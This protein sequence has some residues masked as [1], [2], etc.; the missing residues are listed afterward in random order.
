[1]QNAGNVSR[2]QRVQR[3]SKQRVHA[4]ETRPIKEKA[5][6]PPEREKWNLETWRIRR[7]SNY[8]SVWLTTTSSF[9]NGRNY[10]QNAWKYNYSRGGG[11]WAGWV[12][13]FPGKSSSAGK[14]RGE[15]G[16]RE[17]CAKSREPGRRHL[18]VKTTS[19]SFFFFFFF[20]FS[21]LQLRIKFT[22]LPSP[23]LPPEKY[24]FLLPWFHERCSNRAVPRAY[25]HVATTSL[26]INVF[27]SLRLLRITRANKIKP[28]LQSHLGKPGSGKK[29]RQTVFP[30]FSSRK[31][32]VEY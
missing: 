5:F 26:W 31:T 30:S 4:R 7:R 8:V 27:L 22:P 1:M 14:H 28:T 15:G 20:F 25:S 2:F 17:G 29:P 13:C 9:I 6:S 3:I 18:H 21:G 10:R 19:I 11:G 23:S 24:S 12:H 16:R 32:N